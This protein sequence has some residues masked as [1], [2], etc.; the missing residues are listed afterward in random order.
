MR[1]L[2]VLAST[3]A[4]LW[5][6]SL[7]AQVA[8]PRGAPPARQVQAQAQ[9]QNFSGSLV[10]AA[11][12]QSTPDQKCAVNAGTTTF[13][14]VTGGKL[15]KFDEAGNSMA[16]KEM[17]KTGAK[18]GEPSATVAGILEGDTIKVESVQIR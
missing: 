6:C 17:E 14:L 12:K 10:D 15:L 4:V 11:C 5:G 9:P 16:S 7:L 2:T 1:K 3:I 8:A 13:G 18:S